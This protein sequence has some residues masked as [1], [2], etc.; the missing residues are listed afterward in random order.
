MTSE[1]GLGQM[2]G[3]LDMASVG[4]ATIQVNRI[5]AIPKGQLGKWRMITALS[6]PAGCSVNDAIDPDLC[7]L[8]YTTVERVK[9]L[10]A[11][12]LMAK[13]DIES[14]Y[15]L[16]LVHTQDQTLL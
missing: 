4:G 10:G 6:H 15:H 16:V 5:G 2:L 12:A 13:A 3:P 14:A 1:A 7:S 11:G 8:T 9:R